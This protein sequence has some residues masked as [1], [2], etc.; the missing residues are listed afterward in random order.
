MTSMGTREGRTRRSG[1]GTNPLVRYLDVIVVLLATPVVLALGAP[2][3]GFLVGAGAWIVQRV[4]GELDRSFIGRA[5]EPRTKLGL[6]LFEAFGRIW[7]LAGA[8]IAAGVIG[9]REDGLTAAITIFCAYSIAFVIR[10]LSGP[11]QRP[12]PR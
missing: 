7:L 3:L 6:H 1:N 10:L 11:P 12:V 5:R 4:L 8:I 2:V 9:G